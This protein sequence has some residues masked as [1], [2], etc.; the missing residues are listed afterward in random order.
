MLKMAIN[1]NP[2]WDM[3]ENAEAR[4]ERLR[5]IDQSYKQAVEIIYGDGEQTGVADQQIE[6]DPLF[7]SMRDSA[8]DMRSAITTPSMPEE[9]MG[10]A[11]LE[12][13]R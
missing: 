4:G 6:N 2:N 13:A 1:S 12:A 7:R 10:A 5:V 11:L 8:V 3:K 9:G